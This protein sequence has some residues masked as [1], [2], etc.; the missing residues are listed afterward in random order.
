M[1]KYIYKER[2]VTRCYQLILKEKKKDI[3]SY[4]T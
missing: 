3:L 4:E 2:C 1:V